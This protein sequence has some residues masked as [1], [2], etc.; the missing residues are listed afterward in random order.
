MRSRQN[1]E[2]QRVEAA[3]KRIL[4]VPIS[5]GVPIF[6]VMWT[7]DMICG[8][9]RVISGVQAPTG[10]M[11]GGLVHSRLRRRLYLVTHIAS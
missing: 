8:C 9:T 5:P 7:G 1:L 10:G 3:E 6:R 11:R 4:D 2:N